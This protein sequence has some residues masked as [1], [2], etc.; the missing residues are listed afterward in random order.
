MLMASSVEGRFPFLDRDLIELSTRIDPRLMMRGLNE[1]HVLK[2]AFGALLPEAITR[3]PKQPYRAPGLDFFQKAGHASGLARELLSSTLLDRYA[4]F[5]S[6]KVQLL[7]RK[8]ARPLPLSESDSMALSCVLSTQF[9]HH[10]FIASF[11]ESSRQ[12]TATNGNAPI[13]RRPR[14]AA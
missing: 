8:A 3:R 5:D 2:R 1:K 12:P 6:A 11:D 7:L 10:R 13:L 4:Y 9:L 14:V